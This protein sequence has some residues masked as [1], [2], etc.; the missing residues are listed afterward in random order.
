MLVI[1]VGNS[2]SRLVVP[3]YA[4]RLLEEIGQNLAITNPADFYSS[5]IEGVRPK[6]KIS[7]GGRG[8]TRPEF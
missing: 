5:T 2:A 6:S 1:H 8:R 7:V 4:T 3:Y